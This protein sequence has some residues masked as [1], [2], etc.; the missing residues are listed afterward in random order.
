VNEGSV[1][2]PSI[3]NRFAIKKKWVINIL[4]T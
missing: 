1:K 3:F 2:L 4:L